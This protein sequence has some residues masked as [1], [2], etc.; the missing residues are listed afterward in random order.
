MLSFLSCVASVTSDLKQAKETFLLILLFSF[1]FCIQSVKFGMN[2]SQAKHGAEQSKGEESEVKVALSS[3]HCRFQQ[4]GMTNFVMRVLAVRGALFPLSVRHLLE[5]L[6]DEKCKNDKARDENATQSR[7]AQNTAHEALQRLD[8]TEARQQE[9]ENQ[10]G[11][12]NEEPEN[13]I[14][15]QHPTKG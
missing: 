10:N 13:N 9:D 6:H 5:A 14:E 7:P 4:Q 12:Q 2:T 3:K 15:L 8:G 1:Q 11:L